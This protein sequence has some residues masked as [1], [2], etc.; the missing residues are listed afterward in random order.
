[1]AT[2]AVHQNPTP[3][4]RGASLTESADGRTGLSG[5]LQHWFFK[6]VDASSLAVF[7]IVF[8]ALLL[9]E[10]VNYGVFL[11]LDCMYRDTGA[12]VQVSP[13]R[14]G[15]SCRPGYGLEAMFVGMTPERVLRH[16]RAVLPSRDDRLHDPVHV[17]VS[18]ST[19]RST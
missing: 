3:P 14:M 8:G 11:C 2:R 10:S 5:Q 16:G 19:R 4:T 13:F 1:M 9:F 15:R 12:A 18:C 6:P 17:V 7:R